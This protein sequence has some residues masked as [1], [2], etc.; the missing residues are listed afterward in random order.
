MAR[1]ADLPSLGITTSEEFIQ[2][3]KGAQDPIPIDSVEP[4]SSSSS[5]SI[6][7]IELAQLAWELSRPGQQST[8]ALHIPQLPSVLLGWLL[9]TLSTA[10]KPTGKAKAAASVSSESP[11][12]NPAYYALLDSLTTDIDLS[13]RARNSLSSIAPR[14]TPQ[15]IV[16]IAAALF[17]TNDEALFGS[18]LPVAAKPLSKLLGPLMP[19]LLS[20]SGTR[21][22][23]EEAL[24][25]ICVRIGGLYQ[26]F[27]ED[28]AVLQSTT[29]LVQTICIPA[30]EASVDGTSSSSSKVSGSHRKTGE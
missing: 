3:L 12:T 13:A 29:R 11:L 17:K 9:D 8:S 16:S 22:A 20:S 15:S 24:Q 25:S 27:E 1:F 4:S 30:V 10:A 26:M 21:Q 28:D 23:V 2:K 19:A 5:S 6:T 14:T 18:C 7:K